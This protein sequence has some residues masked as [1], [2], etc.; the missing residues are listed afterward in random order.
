MR[1]LNVW[2]S[3]PLVFICLSFDTIARVDPPGIQPCAANIKG[4]VEGIYSDSWSQKFAVK[5][6]G[7]FYYLSYYSLDANSREA[8]RVFYNAMTLNQKV[9]ILECQ[10]YDIS[11]V[12]ATS[13]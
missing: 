4:Y 5:I 9:T 2:M 7:H 12:M 10:G 13:S 8:V 1:K 11:S 3:I 6:K